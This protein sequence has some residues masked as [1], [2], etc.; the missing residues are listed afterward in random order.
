MGAGSSVPEA[1]SGV[2]ELQTL[3]FQRLM[4]DARLLDNSIS[5]TDV[6]TV[7]TRVDGM[8]NQGPRSKK[9]G[10]R[11]V[12]DIPGDLKINFEE[13]QLAMQQIARLRY[14]EASSEEQAY[15]ALL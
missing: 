2:Y 8:A 5:V 11:G 9:T 13:F 15:K 6:D 14:P 1:D 10:K 7:F 3:G 12:G 4:R